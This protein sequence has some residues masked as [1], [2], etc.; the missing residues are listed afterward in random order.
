MNLRFPAGTA[1]S[2]ELKALEQLNK[3]LTFF[4]FQSILTVSLSRS[5]LGPLYSFLLSTN[6][7]RVLSLVN[8]WFRCLLTIL[9]IVKPMTQS[10]QTEGKWRI[11]NQSS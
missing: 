5:Y 3:L 2:L 6:Y 4:N 9:T 10:L 11:Y 1:G 7:L 8:F